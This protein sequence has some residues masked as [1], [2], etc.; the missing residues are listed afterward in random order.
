MSAE[1]TRPLLR[2]KPGFARRLK[3]GHPWAYSNEIDIKPEH[4]AWPPGGF[5]RLEGDD[6][7]KFGTFSFNPHSLIAARR[8]DRSPAAVIDEKWLLARL[9]A[10]LAL[11]TRLFATPFY[12]LVHAEADGLPG[13]IVDRYGDALAV[14]ANIAAI[15][16][17]TEPLVAALRSLLAPRVIVARNDSPVRKLEGLEEGRGFLWGSEAS[18]E[19]EEG[20][21]VFP[22]DLLTGQKTGWFF[23]Q[24]PN[25]DAVAKLA[26][27]ARVLDVFAH[28]G[29]FGLRCAASGAG[30]VHLIDSSLAALERAEEAM[31]RNGLAGVSLERA[32]A[33]EAMERF[34]RR[35]ER[36]DIVI[37]DPP[38][39]APTRKDRGPALR[40]YSK[41]TRLAAEL[42]SPGGFLFVASC[43]YHISGADF[44]AAVATGLN[45]AE[46]EG[47]IVQSGGAGPDHPVHPHLPESAYLKTQWIQLF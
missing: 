26:A 39:F 46:R 38:A 23:D 12:R 19:V 32:D 17:L 9:E 18:A 20:G 15:E 7:T 45:R 43:S 8:F 21:L 31:K 1:L 36:F 14:Q 37:C 33:F 40:A 13:C 4:R 27:G 16:R 34:G 35:G 10:A 47:R 29:A 22:V 3:G 44:A 24:R 28:T 42:V 11:R 30:R 2:L 5:V 25:R 6:G 41:M